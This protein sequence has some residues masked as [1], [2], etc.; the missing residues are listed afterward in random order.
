MELMR[1]NYLI[2]KNIEFNN[3]YVKNMTEICI[4]PD[5]PNKFDTNQDGN[6]IKHTK[7]EDDSF[8][9]GIFYNEV[10]TTKGWDL[11]MF[12]NNMTRMEQIPVKYDI[13]L[14]RVEQKLNEWKKKAKTIYY[15]IE[16]YRVRENSVEFLVMKEKLGLPKDATLEEV[17]NKPAYEVKLEDIKRMELIKEESDKNEIY[18]NIK[19]IPREEVSTLTG[20]LKEL[21]SKPKINF[22]VVINKSSLDREVY[23]HYYEAEPEN[24]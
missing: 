13:V 1:N 8:L 9:E 10:R 22:D 24:Y 6:L 7:I 17:F 2:F 5:I 12:I 15:D 16:T 3:K 11:L 21:R 14:L 23:T 20:E 19:I 18:R 4:A